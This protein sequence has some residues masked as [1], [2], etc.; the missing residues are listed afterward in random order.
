MVYFRIEMREKRELHCF[1]VFCG[2]SKGNGDI[3]RKQAYELGHTLAREGRSVVYGGARVGLMGQ[4]ARGTIDGGGH[5][6]GVIPGF[7]KEREI[8]HEGLNRLIHV[9]SM[10]ERKQ[11]MHQLSDAVIAM[12]GGFGTL[13]EL[14]EMLT[15]AQLGIH[16]KPVAL[17]NVNGYYDALEKQ[18]DNM[19]QEG[20]LKP[21]NRQMLII[22]SDIREM[23]RLMS[24]QPIPQTDKWINR[25]QW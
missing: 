6:T 3:Y 5:I 1:A 20:F 24:D 23:L 9:E 19:V 4:L 12:P 13:E 22:H 17:L 7:L 16:Q 11:M 21:A 15:W 25:D 8:M 14:F 18:A 2:S 10:H